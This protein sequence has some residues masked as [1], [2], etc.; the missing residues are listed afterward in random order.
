M[1]PVA[2]DPFRWSGRRWF[3]SVA[4]VFALQGGLLLYLGQR[5]L[6]VPVRPT[7]RTA[8]YSVSDSWFSEQLDRNPTINDP[9]L[10][11][12]PGE[13][14]FSGPA[15]MQP[16]PLEYVPDR[17]TEPIRWLALGEQELGRD[18]LRAVSTN[19]LVPPSVAE[20]VVPPLVRYE[21]HFPSDPIVQQ[22]R[23]SYEGELAARSL[24]LPIPLRSWPRTELLSNSII[25]TAIDS[26]GRSL[27]PALIAECGLPEADRL[28]LKLAAQIRFRPLPH[29]AR[30]STKVGP[31]AWGKLI[32]EWHTAPV[33]A[34]NSVVPGP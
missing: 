10:F 24:P 18:F 31:L 9:T 28:A 12:L 27:F 3:Y 29:D 20:Q 30:D 4:A 16:A 1:N 32:F 26:D 21:P 8:V 23:L 34:T 14:G 19:V 22:S 7:F 11:A 6:P 25:R 17:W 2:A 15:W 33:S 5:E 13:N